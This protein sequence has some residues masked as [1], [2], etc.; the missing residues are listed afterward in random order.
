MSEPLKCVKY[1]LKHTLQDPAETAPVSSESHAV[2]TVKEAIVLFFMFVLFSL[3][4]IMVF[5]SV[6]CRIKTW[7]SLLNILFTVVAQ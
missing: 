4:S 6:S 1:T 5:F 3:D 2:E 7:F